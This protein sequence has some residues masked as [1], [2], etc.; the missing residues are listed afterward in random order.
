MKI[1][2]VRRWGLLK[3]KKDVC[4]LSYD[5]R[6]VNTYRKVLEPETSIENVSL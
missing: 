3:N 6:I 1:I 4:N 2:W 5:I